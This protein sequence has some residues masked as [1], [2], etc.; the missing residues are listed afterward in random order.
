M[1]E[2][3]STKVLVA[4]CP[5]SWCTFTAV[6]DDPQTGYEAAYEIQDHVNSDHSEMDMETLGEPSANTDKSDGG[7]R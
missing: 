1:G 6:V 7:S 2:T 4:E 5:M 3:D